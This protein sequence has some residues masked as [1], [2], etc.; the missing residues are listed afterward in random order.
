MLMKMILMMAGV[1]ASLAAGA[2]F[3]GNVGT[4]VDL[5]VALGASLPLTGGGVASI[6][7]IALVAGIRMLRKKKDK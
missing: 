7:A 1:S 4:P 6:A 2:A 3:A 5:G